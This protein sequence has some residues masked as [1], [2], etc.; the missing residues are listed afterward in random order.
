MAEHDLDRFQRNAAFQG[1]G[2]G[3]RMPGNMKSEGEFNST[4]CLYD[5]EATVNF[6]VGDLWKDRP[7]G[8]KTGPAAVF[9]EEGGGRLQEGDG[10]Q[11]LEG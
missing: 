1:D 10:D 11:L 2:F 8:N 3:K 7:A 6:L 5:L 9:V 4:N